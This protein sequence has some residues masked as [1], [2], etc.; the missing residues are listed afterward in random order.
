VNHDDGKDDR[1]SEEDLRAAVQCIVEEAEDPDE[2]TIYK[3]QYMLADKFQR[4]LPY[5]KRA[6]VAECFKAAKATA[7]AEAKAKADAEA[8]AKADAEA[9]AKADAEAKEK[10]DAEAKAT[11]D[12]AAAAKKKADAEAKAKPDDEERNAKKPKIRET[13]GQNR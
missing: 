1:P 9:K 10:A 12:A 2:L 6:F 13:T 11:A 4:S 5:G 8:E 3:V 7:D